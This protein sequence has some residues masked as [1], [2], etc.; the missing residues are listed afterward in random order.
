MCL[1][2]LSS[3]LVH[4]LLLLRTRYTWMLALWWWTSR[5][6]TLMLLVKSCQARSDNQEC[7]EEAWPLILHLI[8]PFT[9]TGRV[10]LNLHNTSACITWV[11]FGLSLF[12]AIQSILVS[13]DNKC[14]N[15]NISYFGF[16]FLSWLHTCI[17]A[18]TFIQILLKLASLAAWLQKNV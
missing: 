18:H 8:Q 12:Y 11:L 6:P 1:R 7:I 9:C 4:R 13:H 16:M 3:I 17:I 10:E 2:L 14:A 5:S 15:P